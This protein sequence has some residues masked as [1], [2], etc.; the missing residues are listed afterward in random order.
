MKLFVY[1]LGFIYKENPH[2]N[3]ILTKEQMFNTIKFVKNQ[4]EGTGITP[5]CIPAE[6][7]TVE[8]FEL[9]EEE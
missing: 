8:I 2:G 1:R 4:L 6:V 5:I 9:G 7:S 3:I